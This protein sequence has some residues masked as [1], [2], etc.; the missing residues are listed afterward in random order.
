MLLVAH[1]VGHMDG[2][3]D[4]MDDSLEGPAA[5]MPP[6]VPPPA[7]PLIRRWFAQAEAAEAQEA[8]ESAAAEARLARARDA[9][10]SMKA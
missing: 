8:A 9:G 10:T 1:R 4:V 3:D 5:P 7:S 6:R 2:G